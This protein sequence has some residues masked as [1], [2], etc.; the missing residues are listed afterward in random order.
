[1]IR[2]ENVSFRAAVKVHDRCVFVGYA[3]ATL[4]VPGACFDGSD[5]LL[6]CESI[7]V[8]VM[9]DGNPRVDFKSVQGSDKN[10]YPIVS[11]RSAETRDSITNA[12]LADRTVMAV[13]QSIVE[14][15]DAGRIVL[16]A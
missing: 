15:L 4:I 9:R 1:M 6:R 13:V 7:E 11:P 10:W 8:K 5:L 14:D 2:F 3:N 16:A 12:L